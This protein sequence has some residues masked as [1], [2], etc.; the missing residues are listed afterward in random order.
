MN[1]QTQSANLPKHPK[2]TSGVN[3]V[4]FHRERSKWQAYIGVSGGTEVLGYF[5]TVEEAATAR[6]EADVKYGFH[7]EHGK[8][9]KKQY[10]TRKKPKPVFKEIDGQ[11]PDGL[12]C[13]CKEKG[14]RQ[15]RLYVRSGR[16]RI[17]IGFYPTLEAV[18]E[19]KMA[20]AAA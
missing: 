3:G 4:K 13:F 7:P 11:V 10:N 17:H 8:W 15:Y 12:L 9:V 19:A 20:L 16:S 18:T 5:D 2:N 1:K 6:A 14:K